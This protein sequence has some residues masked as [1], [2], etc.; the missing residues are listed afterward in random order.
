MQRRTPPSFHPLEFGV[1]RALEKHQLTQWPEP[2]FATLATPD[3]LR[4]F[5]QNGA[6]LLLRQAAVYPGLEQRLGCAKVRRVVPGC[7]A[8]ARLEL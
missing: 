3:L 5:A 6:G 1:A 2:H 8:S 4:V 7:F